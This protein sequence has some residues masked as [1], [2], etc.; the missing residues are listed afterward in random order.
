[1]YIYVFSVYFLCIIYISVC[2]IYRQIMSQV[3]SSLKRFDS[4]PGKTAPQPEVS[5]L[6]P[7]KDDGG[8]WEDGF[9]LFKL[10][11]DRFL[12][13]TNLQNFDF[14][15]FQHQN[16]Q[17]ENGENRNTE[18]VEIIAN[19]SV[20]FVKCKFDNASSS[21]FFLFHVSCFSCPIRHAP[22]T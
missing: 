8:T 13:Q 14:S 21:L 2:I 15:I 17:G 5:Y 7:S 1:M 19:L 3:K 18:S 6:Q 4:Q 12:I 20:K 9:K 10:Q 16:W 22:N 11:T